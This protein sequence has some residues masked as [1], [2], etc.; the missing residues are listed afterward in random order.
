MADTKLW[1]MS[2]TELSA[3]TRAGEVSATDATLSALGRLAEVN[4]GLNA[5]VVDLSDEAL[6]EALALE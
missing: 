4:P 3:L 5:V 2:A 6:A 1:Q